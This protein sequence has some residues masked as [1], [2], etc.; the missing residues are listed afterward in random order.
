M[1]LKR[2]LPSTAIFRWKLDLYVFF[3]IIPNLFDDYIFQSQ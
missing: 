2:A 3:S 1:S